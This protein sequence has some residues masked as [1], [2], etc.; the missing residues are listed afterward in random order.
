MKGRRFLDHTGGG[1]AFFNMMRI[2]PQERIG[3]VVMGNASGY[4]RA[5]IAEAALRYNEGP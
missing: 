4:D 5:P 2:Y 3:V 1:G